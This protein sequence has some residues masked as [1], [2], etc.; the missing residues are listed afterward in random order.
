M[1]ECDLMG[2][3]CLDPLMVRHRRPIYGAPPEPSGAGAAA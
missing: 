1:S 2:D 3:Y